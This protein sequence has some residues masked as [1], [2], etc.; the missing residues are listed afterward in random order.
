MAKI[1]IDCDG[2]LANFNDGFVE[3]VNKMFP[4][5][6]P[7][8][9]VPATWDW[10]GYLTEA[11]I[12]KLFKRIKSTENWWLSLSAYPEAIGALSTW[13][14]GVAGHDIWIVTSRIETMGMTVAKQTEWWLKS[15]AIYPVHNYLGVMPVPQS[16]MKAA[17]YEAAEF[18]YSIDDK[19]ETVEQC[20]EMPNHKAYLLSQPWNRD[21]KVKHRVK[22]VAEFLKEIGK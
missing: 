1:A 13:M 5:R 18:D 16:D 17:L 11:E 15:C 6:L 20:D 4:N 10:D 22:S 14:I 9:Y 3:L 12:D 19:G 2:V 21:A 8:G 7:R